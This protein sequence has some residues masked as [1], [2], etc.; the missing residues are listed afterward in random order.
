MF[1]DDADFLLCL[2]D[3]SVLF[4]RDLH[5]VDRD[6]NTALGRILEAG[7]LDVIQHLCGNGDTVDLDAVVN[8]LAE[9]LLLDDESNLEIQHLIRVA[10]VDITEVL[11]NLPVEDESAE[12][13]IDQLGILHAIDSL[14]HTDANR[15][16]QT[17]LTVGIRH[18][19]LVHIAE[20]ASCARLVL[21][22]HRQIVRAEDHVLRRHRDG[23]TVG[24]LQQVVGRQHEEARLCLRLCGQ[25][26]MDRHLVAVEVGV[27]CR[28]DQRVELDCSALDQYRLEC[29]NGQSVQ[30]RCTVQQN[31]VLLD[32]IFKCIPN[33]GI[34]LVDLLLGFLDVGSLLRLDQALHDEGLEEF[35][36]HFLRQTALE[37]LQI[38]ADD[39]NR[40]A[41]IVHALAEQVLTE[42][43][44]LAAQHLG[45]RLER[46]VG[47]SGDR[48]A[49][50]AVVDQGID[51]LLQHALLVAHDDLGR[52]KLHQLLQAVVA[53][54][55]AAVQII[56]VGGGKS[57][58]VELHHRADFRREH[59]H[60]IENHPLGAVVRQ[61]EC[62]DNLQAL[63]DLQL[64]LTAGMLQLLFQLLGELFDIDFGEQL[65]NSLRAHTDAEIV[66]VALIP[67]VVFLL[68]EQLLLLQ[69]GRTG[70][71]DDILREIEHALEVSRRD[72]E[73]QTDAGRDRAEVP[74]VRHRRGKLDVAHALAANLFGR[75]LDA[76]LLTDLALV[77]DALVF[78]AEAFPVLRRPEN[79][80]T[81]QTV[82]LCLQRSVVDRFGLRDLT[83]RPLTD[84][85]GRREAYLDRIKNIIHLYYHL[86][87]AP[88]K[89]LSY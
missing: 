60:D 21:V 75:D 33:L 68:A 46:T 54:D 41:G 57:A 78:A 77:A 2:G 47:R 31:R 62:L 22:G 71:N 88:Q 13:G 17:E 72:V 38:R 67:L 52:M 15:R 59:R 9:L 18:L 45:Q 80:L 63:D 86:L 85:L 84:H 20:G 74:D 30:R 29:L 37:D 73:Q 27:E 50:S 69:T 58:A 70:I 11:R 1:G 10:A 25:R 5:V 26:H 66:L 53:I 23:T 32:D 4:G 42:A 6:R 12:R 8:D 28:A 36:C 16:M 82:L 76:A 44:L 43:S 61:S 81:E 55:D 14:L 87:R 51:R 89:H 40:T 48:L 83:V 24:R 79:A 3:L 7:C 49:A 65:L 64:L 35:K 34:H 39:D 19:R 56:Q